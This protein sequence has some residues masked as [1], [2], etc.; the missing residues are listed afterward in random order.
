MYNYAIIGFGGLGRVHLLS[1]TKI[2]ER[3]KDFQLKAICGTSPEKF[4]ENVRTNL[5]SAD[6]SMIDFGGINFYEDYKELLEN[7]KIDFALLVLPTYLHEEAAVYCLNRGV[8]VFSEK[9]M[10]LTLEG[11]D[12]MIKAAED[13]GCKLMIGHCLRFDTAYGQLKR[14]IDDETF[15]KVR[16]AE[17]HRYSQTPTW[18]WKNWL[19]DPKLSGGCLMD[20]HIHDVD[21]VNWYFGMPKAVSSVSTS[22]KVEEESIFT[23]YLY[24]DMVVTAG[25]DWSMPDEYPFMA[26]CLVNF[27]DATA[28]IEGG[29]LTIY[30]DEKGFYPERDIDTYFIKEMKAFLKYVIDGRKCYLTDPEQIRE[31]VRLALAERESAKTKQIV[32]L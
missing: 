27:E 3:R 6:I 21:L 17:F 24:D 4:K 29:E 25:A 12:N 14:Y 31:S 13:N 22:V 1:M 16:R 18:S 30:Q 9:P 20:M 10:A 32:Y 8:H 19:L 23:Q 2:Q 26:R 28:V 11:C 5:G 7:E 15:G